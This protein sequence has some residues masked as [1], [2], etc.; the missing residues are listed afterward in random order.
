[1]NWIVYGQTSLASGQYMDNPD[2]NRAGIN[3]ES[4]LPFFIPAGRKLTIRSQGIE[5]NC[6]PISGLFVYLGQA[7]GEA[8][9]INR[10]SLPTVASGYGSGQYTGLAWE[11]EGPR[12]VNVRI[13][14]ASKISRVHGW[15]VAGELS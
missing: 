5:G 12:T 1:M 6:A 14:N 15:Y 9:D 4:S 10:R 3:G 2:T 11:I 7:G 8:D 13:M